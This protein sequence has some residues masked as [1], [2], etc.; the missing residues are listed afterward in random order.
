MNHECPTESRPNRCSAAPKSWSAVL[1]ASSPPEPRSSLPFAHAAKAQTVSGVG[2]QTRGRRGDPAG[3]PAPRIRQ[4]AL[5]EM[6]IGS[7]A[8]E[9]VRRA[10]C[11]L[12]L[13]NTWS[14]PPK[15]ALVVAC[16]T[17]STGVRSSLRPP[18][19]FGSRRHPLLERRVC[20]RIAPAF[21]AHL[22]P[23]ARHAGRRK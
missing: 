17:S 6:R 1:A 5:R 21:S 22:H 23:E 16:R 11:L 7:T 20:L 3:W 8:A 13:R 19:T 4:R 12:L 15:A 14:A 18:R 2:R 10:P 9:F